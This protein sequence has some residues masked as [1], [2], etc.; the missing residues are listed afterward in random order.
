M[1]SD[2]VQQLRA[3]AALP[4]MLRAV[5]MPDLHPGK[6][7]PIGSHQLRMIRRLVMPIGDSHA[8]LRTLAHGAGRK[9][10]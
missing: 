6:G 1:E 4:G 3:S 7:W 5:G 2:A 8:N 9:W 10:K